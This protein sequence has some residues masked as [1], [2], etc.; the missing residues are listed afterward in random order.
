MR[1]GGVEGVSANEYTA[2]NITYGREPI[3]LSMQFFRNDS[4]VF[5]EQATVGPRHFHVDRKIGT[6]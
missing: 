6:M 3:R 2:V 5:P 4:Q 1:G